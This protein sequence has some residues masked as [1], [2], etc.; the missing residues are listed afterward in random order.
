M[1]HITISKILGFFSNVLTIFLRKR[2]YEIV[3]HLKKRRDIIIEKSEKKKRRRDFIIRRGKLAGK[4]VSSYREM[5]AYEKE[6]DN[7]EQIEK[8]IKN[9][10]I[11]KK[12][13]KISANDLRKKLRKK[14][15]DSLQME[16]TLESEFHVY[17]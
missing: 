5:T 11:D 8:E 15:N 1:E 9:K 10:K 12:L 13:L 3:E 17:L 16:K 2:Y 6:I 14:E 7:L 4:L